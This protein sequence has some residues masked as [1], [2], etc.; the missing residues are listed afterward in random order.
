[1]DTK[2]AASLSRQIGG[3][4]KDLTALRGFA[5]SDALPGDGSR[6]VLHARAQRWVFL[7]YFRNVAGVLAYLFL[8]GAVLARSQA[9]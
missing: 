9:V 5:L 6:D 8:M 3:G 4:L 1:M 2:V 7:N